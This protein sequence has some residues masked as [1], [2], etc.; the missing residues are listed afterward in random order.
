MLSLI[1]LKELIKK[2]LQQMTDLIWPDIKLGKYRNSKKGMVVEV[3]GI[4]K[5]SETLE[6]FVVYKH[7]G[8]IWIRLYQMFLEEVEVE[9]KIVPRFTKLNI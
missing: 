8:N 9:G 1:S 3:L 6:D 2:C 5:H 7:D 4:A